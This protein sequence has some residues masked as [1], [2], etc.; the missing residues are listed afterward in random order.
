MATQQ[1]PPPP[2]FGLPTNAESQIRNGPASLVD[3]FDDFLFANAA[4]ANVDGNFS[5]SNELDDEDDFDDDDEG[6]QGESDDGRKRKRPRSSHRSMTEEQ[7]VE[8]R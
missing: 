7:K 4:S 3:I 8:R 5:G 2:V 1:F 6:S